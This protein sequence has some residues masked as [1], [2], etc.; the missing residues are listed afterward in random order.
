MSTVLSEKIVSSS[1]AIHQDDL[2]LFV[3][4]IWYPGEGVIIPQTDICNARRACDA[5]AS[6]QT[7]YRSR[8]I[9]L[10]LAES[11]EDNHRYAIVAFNAP[12]TS[13]ASGYGA[14]RSRII[15]EVLGP[16]I[17]GSLM[18]IRLKHMAAY[19]PIAYRLEPMYGQA[20]LELTRDWFPMD[21][22]PPLSRPG[23]VKWSYPCVVLLVT[24]EMVIA[25][26]VDDL[27]HPGLRWIVPNTNFRDV[28]EQALRW[29]PQPDLPSP[30]Y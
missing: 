10:K 6:C 14:V 20:S 21:V 1:P 22:Q 12:S 9:E 8:V 23:I 18:S 13:S 7:P 15:H 5:Q 4:L 25:V 24:G 16:G 30:E 3:K 17:P 2:T 28:T 26:L 29:Q 11:V 27:Y 19:D